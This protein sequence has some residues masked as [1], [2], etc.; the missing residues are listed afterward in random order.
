MNLR[1]SFCAAR[2]TGK[3]AAGNE[4]AAAVVSG[5]RSNQKDA[6]TNV[7]RKSR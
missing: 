7:E 1:E 4:R 6:V 5:G 3:E 2:P